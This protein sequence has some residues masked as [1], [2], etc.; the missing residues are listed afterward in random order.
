MPA[1]TIVYLKSED[2]T[3]QFRRAEKGIQINTHPYIAGSHAASAEQR[4]HENENHK[5]NDGIHYSDFITGTVNLQALA[6][7][8][9]T[10]L[11][12]RCSPPRRPLVESHLKMS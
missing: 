3:L 1:G 2:D 8:R 6:T 4:G 9:H 7:Q 10:S 11:C 12:F 5:S